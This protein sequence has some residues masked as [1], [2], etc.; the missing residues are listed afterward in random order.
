[1]A[2]G[3]RDVLALSGVWPSAPAAAPTGA[4]FLGLLELSGVWP[5]A[6]AG[7]APAAD[8]GF[9]DLLSLQGVW[10]PGGPGEAPEPREPGAGRPVRRPRL[11]DHLE[12]SRL[13]E[14]RLRDERDWL[15]FLLLWQSSDRWRH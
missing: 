7:G 13:L 8:V 12:R 4:G 10:F 6:P 3:F 2:A 11:Y 5:S 15:D 1:M 14:R 9:L